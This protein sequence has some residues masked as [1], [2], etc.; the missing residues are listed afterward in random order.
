MILATGEITTKDRAA[1]WALSHLPPNLHPALSH[2]REV[3]LDTTKEDWPH[4]AHRP[5]RDGNRALPL[6]HFRPRACDRYR[7]PEQTD[8]H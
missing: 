4:S 1:T 7:P 2:T 3:Y 8:P 5:P 6:S